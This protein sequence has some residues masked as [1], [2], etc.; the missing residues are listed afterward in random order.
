MPQD[1]LGPA[2]NCFPKARLLDFTQLSKAKGTTEN[3]TSA[4]D[5]PFDVNRAK[6]LQIIWVFPGFLPI[7]LVLFQNTAQGKCHPR[8]L[9]SF[10]VLRFFAEI[11]ARPFDKFY[12]EDRKSVV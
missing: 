10:R 11:S 4:D 7:I 12:M 1:R 6:K 8:R 2:M 9:E 5:Q 3:C